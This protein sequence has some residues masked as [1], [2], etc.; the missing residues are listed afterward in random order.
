M[1]S[2]AHA[3]WL[4]IEHAYPLPEMSRTPYAA[5][6]P[7]LPASLMESLDALERDTAFRSAMGEEFVTYFST[8]KKAEINRFLST[9][10]D[11]VQREYVRL[12]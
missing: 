7:A 5:D 1:P 4:G 8:I 6:A 10:T 9:V 11:W 12:F 3:S 2:S